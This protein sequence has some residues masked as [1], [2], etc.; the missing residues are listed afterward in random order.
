MFSMLI[1]RKCIDRSWSILIIHVTKESFSETEQ[2]QDYE[3]KTVTF[4]VNCALYLALRTILQLAND[5]E[6]TFPLASEILRNC[7]YVDNALVGAHDIPMAIKSKE[8][9]IAAL[10][11][12]GFSLRKWTS[13]SKDILSNLPS[14]HLLNVGF[15]DFDDSSTAKM[16]GIRRNALSDS[17][18]FCTKPFPESC[19]FTKREVLSQISKLLDPAGW[20]S[21]CIVQAKVLMQRIWMEGTNW[22]EILSYDTLAQWKSFQSNYSFI[23]Q[24][25]KFKI[26]ST[27]VQ[28]HCF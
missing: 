21:P 27:K 2:L 22:D 1:Y 6:S 19:E 28:F 15:L 26:N 16:L 23:N 25:H 20:L 11:S 8:D 24:I 12:A 9:L 3:L 13:N 14:E 10:E 17:F 18:F 5:V 4:C 7:M